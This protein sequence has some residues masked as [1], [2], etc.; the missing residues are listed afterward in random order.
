MAAASIHTL[1][2]D[3]RA[4]DYEGR[5]LEA[6]RRYDILDTPPDGAFDRITAI[7]A[8]LLSTPI[9]IIS[10]VDHDRI[11]FKSHH[12]LEIAQIGRAPGLCA[13][14]IM[15]L[16][17]WV[18]TDAK[19]DARSLANPLVAGDFGLRFYVGIP[20]RTHD[21]F[22][23]GTLCVI[24][25]MPRPVTDEQIAHLQD[26]ASVVMDQ[27]ELRLSGR[28]A[29]NDL[30]QVLAQK[31]AALH[32][33]ALLAKE[34]EH[35]VMNGLQLVSGTL[36]LQSRSTAD[37]AAAEELSAAAK[38]VGSIAQVHRHIY[39][40]N[41]IALVDCKEYLQRLC[42]DLSGMLGGA[43]KI[44]CDG[45]AIKLPT[46]KIVALGLI[47]SELVTNAIKHGKSPIRVAFQRTPEARF[48]L[49]V[50]DAGSGPPDDQAITAGRGLGM[51]IVESQVAKLGGS[52]YRQTGDG[53][54]ATTFVVEFPDDSG[55]T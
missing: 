24:D 55:K 28:R 39:L 18:L 30:S 44:S 48:E 20:L 14:A 13:S 52:L 49:S 27:M 4:A 54:L 15:Q 2:P 33:A 43:G 3:I 26:L 6:L 19:L 9:S 36:M 1:H 21:G 31:D 53:S 29:V 25:R 12:G 17:P 46:D 22:N 23:L 10:L 34:I 16:D 41:D 38:R 7:A 11:W 35:R 47:V 51:K 45:A 32:R 40:S 50:S 8:R 5:R 37:A 42:E